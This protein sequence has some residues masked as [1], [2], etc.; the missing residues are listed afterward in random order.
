M[1]EPN[2]EAEGETPAEEPTDATPEAEP[3][4]EAEAGP[5]AEAEPK[6]EAPA[7][8][9]PATPADPHAEVAAEPPRPVAPPRPDVR[10]VGAIYAV[11][12]LLALYVFAGSVFGGELNTE[13]QAVSGLVKLFSVLLPGYP[14]A[15]GLAALGTGRAPGV[16][17]NPLRLPF[18]GWW[19]RTL[20]T[21]TRREL[22][23]ILARPTAYIV[24]FF[25]FMANGYLFTALIAYYGNPDSLNGNF[26]VPAS[27]WICSNGITWITLVL[28]CPA[29]TMR[30][31]S[32]EQRSG[33]LE[34][35]LTA[36][37]T[38]AQ[39]VLSKYFGVLV[40]Y[41]LLIGALLGYV[42]ILR[43]Y[44]SETDWDWG[45]VLGGMLGLYLVGCLFL[46]IGLFASS[47]TQTQLVAFLVALL[48]T[49][50]VFFLNFANGFVEKPWIK[51][52]LRH[53]D[54]Q[55]LQQDLIKGVVQTST[56]AYYVSASIF[57]LFLA[58]RG[59]ESHRW[60]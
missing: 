6:A 12:G 50:G 58:V 10:L 55:A 31:L 56:V 57:F 48:F 60:R 15:L 33:T 17:W 36:P 46:S 9:Q 42:F 53:V 29:L 21:M 39:V 18:D 25:F 13:S 14:L 30:L 41:T 34:M 59:V 23:G 35:L 47:L 49:G 1:T 40:F 22:L 28:I 37:V 26:S 4:A 45:P 52:A 7:S 38:D 43:G 27:Y 54:V 24:L 5:Q 44:A 8:E 19:F 51:S 16:A 3:K 32:E 11:L 2:S 20:G